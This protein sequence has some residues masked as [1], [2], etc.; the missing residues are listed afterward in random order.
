M[1]E[2]TEELLKQIEA[3][4][5]HLKQ[6]SAKTKKAAIAAY[7]DAAYA[8]AAAIAATYAVYAVYAVGAAYAASKQ[9]QNKIINKALEILNIK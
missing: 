9:L 7:A 4:R 6:P 8:D 3:A 5:A 1:I 2:I